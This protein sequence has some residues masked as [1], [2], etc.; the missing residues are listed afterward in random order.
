MSNALYDKGRERF[1]TGQV[2]WLTDTIKVS[3]IDTNDYSFSQTHEYY[4]SVV[5]VP[6]A[7][8]ATGTLAGKNAANGVA[9]ANDLTLTGVSGDASEAL[10]I[11]KDTGDSATSPL[12][13]YI[14]TATGLPVTPNSGDITIVWDNGPNKIF[15]L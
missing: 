10:I 9:D 2:N 14:D 6:S 11:W 12:L 1:L 13:A 7:V 3:L 4:S 5:V 15:K 8:V